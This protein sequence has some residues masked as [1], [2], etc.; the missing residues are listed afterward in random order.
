MFNEWHIFNRPCIQRLAK[1]QNQISTNMQVFSLPWKLIPTKMN[2][3]TVFQYML[4][5]LVLVSTMSLLT[6]NNICFPGHQFSWMVWIS[7]FVKILFRCFANVWAYRNSLNRNCG[8]HKPTK[9]HKK[10]EPL[11]IDESKFINLLEN[12]FTLNMRCPNVNKHYKQ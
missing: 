7:C 1:R 11:N 10:W 12:I 4:Q 8:S 9:I 3:S 2:E 5:N 6:W